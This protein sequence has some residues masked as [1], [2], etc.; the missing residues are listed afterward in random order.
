MEPNAQLPRL[1]I[2][3][4]RRYLVTEDGQPF[5]WLGDTA[6]EMIHRLNKEEVL[7]YLQDR[8]AKGFNVVQTVILAELD[9]LG[10]PNAYGHKPLI[11]HD[12]C[13][14]NDAYFQFVDQIIQWAG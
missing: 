3:P 13:Q 6:W 7:F 5:F 11:G 9:G 14:P 2:S 1:K 10:T 12:P 8:A 4:D